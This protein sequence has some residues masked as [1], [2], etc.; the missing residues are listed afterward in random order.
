MVDSIGRELTVN[1]TTTAGRRQN[2]DQFGRVG[3]VRLKK[4]LFVWL[5]Q[6]SQAFLGQLVAHEILRY[7]VAR[8]AM[9]CH[10]SLLAR[11]E[12]V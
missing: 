12:S 2:R 7:C 5:L 8:A 3:W 10:L 9:S 1:N 6:R 11:R 4:L